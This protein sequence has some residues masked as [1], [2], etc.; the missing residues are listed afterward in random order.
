MI[1]LRQSVA[2]A[3][4][5]HPE[6]ASVFQKHRIDFCCRGE[7]AVE[8][9]CAQRGL[10]PAALAEELSKAIAARSREARVDP[11]GMTTEAL[12]AHIVSTH[13]RYLREALPLVE[14]LAAKVHRVHGAHDPRLAELDAAV[15]ALSELLVP[16]LDEEEQQLFPAM[17]SPEASGGQLAEGLESMQQ[18][19]L[20][21]G[22]LL[23][24]VRRAT[25]DF[26]VPGWACNS[27]R[28][29]FAELEHLEGD[30]LR[31]VHLENHV[32]RPRF[33]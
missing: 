13:H 18:E 12:V 27:Y 23:E 17:T 8:V 33:A 11:R 28:A 19:H 2:S 32:L 3:V 1:D 21:V 6:C 25:G 7:L 9:A 16:H 29:L 4:L 20:E 26:D 30:V 24:Q 31:H 10:E 22:R 14:R 15:G 5:E